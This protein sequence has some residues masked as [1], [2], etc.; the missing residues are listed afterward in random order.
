M[1]DG[2][3]LTPETGMQSD[4]NSLHRVT[5][6][7]AVLA[8]GVTHAHAQQPAERPHGR[9]RVPVVLAMTDSSMGAPGYRIFRRA[10]GGPEDLIVLGSNADPSTFS[11]AVRSLVLIRRA[12]GDTAAV[13]GEVRLRRD[14]NSAGPAAPFPWA[15]RVLGDLRAADRREVP[16]VGRGR[17]VRIFLPAQRVHP[18]RP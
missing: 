9:E 5:L 3:R 10:G 14:A 16:H 13:D 1:G 4:M 8:A 2:L 12:N 15:E 6:I 7:L 11:E 17:A 18:P